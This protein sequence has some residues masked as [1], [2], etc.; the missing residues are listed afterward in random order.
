MKPT[1]RLS[2]LIAQLS[3]ELD[4]RGDQFVQLR[5]I[6]RRGQ[7]L[8]GI[9]G[10]LDLPLLNGPEEPARDLLTGISLPVLYIVGRTGR[11][12]DAASLAELTIAYARSG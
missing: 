11:A 8:I 2:E 9:D 4:R 5:M 6:E 3:A 1:V 7:E 12:L 10:N